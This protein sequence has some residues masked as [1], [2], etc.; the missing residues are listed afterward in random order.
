MNFWQ[1]IKP[2]LFFLSCVPLLRWI[3]LYSTDGLGVDASLF[4]MQSSAQTTFAFLCITLLIAPLRQILRQPNILLV[5]RM[6]GLFT[7]FYACCHLLVWVWGERR[8]NFSLMAQDL[9]ARPG[10]YLGL[11]GFVLLFI[12]A[13][14]SSQGMMR[15]LGRHWIKVHSL[16]Y[17]VGVI[18]IAMFFVMRHPE[19]GYTEAYW[20]AAI[21]A[22]LLCWRIGAYW[23][24]RRNIAAEMLR[25]N[26]KVA[27]L[28]AEQAASQESKN[29]NP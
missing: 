2:L 10:I 19:Q 28:K 25:V 27:A 15:K 24:K 9:S 23:I 8:A 22:V 7:F 11:L 20:G 17:V 21:M 6:F 18:G 29:A 1:K 12:L 3:F 13:I 16:I 26:A 4:M 14:T 5:R